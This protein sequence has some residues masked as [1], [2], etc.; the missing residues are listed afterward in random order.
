MSKTEVLKIAR[1]EAKSKGINPSLYKAAAW[2]MDNKW[3]VIFKRNERSFGWP[4]Y[5]T[6]IVFPDKKAEFSTGYGRQGF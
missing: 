3:R 2:Q 4:I 5:F 1:E 6:V